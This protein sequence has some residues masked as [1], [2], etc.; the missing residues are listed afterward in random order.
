M[1]PAGETTDFDALEDDTQQTIGP[2]RHCSGRV[3]RACQEEVE[4]EEHFVCRCRA[5]QEVRDRYAALFEGHP[6]LSQLMETRDQRQ[7][8]RLLLELHSSRERALQTPALRGERQLRLTDFFQRDMPGIECMPRGVLVHRAAD[9]RARRRPR[10]IRHRVPRIHHR[11]IAAIR[12]RYLMETQERL[13]RFHFDPGR[14]F[15]PFTA[16]TSAMYEILYP[17]YDTGWS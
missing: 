17:T 14:M 7:F 5:H 3:C 11:E 6:P 10:Q 9:L 8:G 1:G 16:S 15:V 4:S 13:A 12:T 2:T